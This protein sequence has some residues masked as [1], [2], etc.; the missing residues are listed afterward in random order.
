M[1]ALEGTLHR[2]LR[3]A[4]ARR[5]QLA[6][7]RRDGAPSPPAESTGHSVVASLVKKE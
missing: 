6:G 2:G 4:R 5:R 1:L 3:N 7:T